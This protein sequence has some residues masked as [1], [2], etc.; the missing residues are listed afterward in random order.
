M[1]LIKK[2]YVASRATVENTNGRDW[3]H[4]TI[5]E[6]VEHARDL[7][8]ET[9]KVQYVVQVIRVISPVRKPVTVEEVE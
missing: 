1:K 9:D 2:Y 7:C 5:D 8:E 4:Q 6:A 3:M